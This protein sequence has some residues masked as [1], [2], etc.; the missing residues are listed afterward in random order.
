MP[1]SAEV[2]PGAELKEGTEGG[3]D[4]G[5]IAAIAG[6]GVSRECYV[7]I[8]RTIELSM[9]MPQQFTCHDLDLT[10]RTDAP[11]DVDDADWGLLLKMSTEEL[12]ASEIGGGRRINLVDGVKTKSGPVS[13]QVI[14]I[15]AGL[16]SHRIE[17]KSKL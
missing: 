4:N 9:M 1:L 13:S 7:G 8:D 10:E 2:R 17:I 12:L 14:E 15:P 6:L 16:G 3:Y 5:R 11:A